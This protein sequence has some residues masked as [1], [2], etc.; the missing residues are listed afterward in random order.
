MICKDYK[1]KT[2]GKL[3]KAPYVCNNCKS[4]G[5]C[6]YERWI[7]VAKYSDDCYHELLSSSREGINQM[8]EDIQKLDTLIS[9]LIKKGQ[10]L[11]HIYANHKTDICCSRR[12]LYKYIDRQ[13]FSA[14]N[15]D[16]PRKVKYKPRKSGTN[17]RNI[18]RN[19]RIGR[20]YDDFNKFLENSPEISVVEMDTVEGQKG[21]KV[22]L[23][24][25]FR[26]STFMLAFLMDNKTQQCVN[27]V[28]SMLVQ[29]LGVKVFKR[30][31]PVILTDNGSE[32]QDPKSIEYGQNKDKLTNVFYC[33]SNCSWQKG[34]IEKNHE[35][36][37]FIVP[38]GRSFDMYNKNDITL[39]INNINSTARDSLN[40]ST[41]FQLSQMLL[42]N[43][44]HKKLS[45]Q[46]IAPDNVVLKP[47]LLK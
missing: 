21:G 14:K 34:M 25:L 17:S 1:P 26:K 43:S 11:S 31:F 41:P 35:Y 10:S 44:L 12:T 3:N 33:D 45:L 15:I 28:F 9:P 30:L 38:K 13:L 29:R 19:Y 39:M 42:D 6:T 32:F 40:G 36:I 16:L 24:L 22:L 7:Y 23:T 27:N 47:T 4:L 5:S 20:T 8:P 2:C 18:S 37:R 46:E